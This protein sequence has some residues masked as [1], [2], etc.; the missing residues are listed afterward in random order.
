MAGLVIVGQ[1]AWAVQDR[2][3]VVRTAQHRHLGL[4]V[5]AAMTIDRDL[6]LHSLKADAV[7]V[8]DSALEP[9]AQE[10]FKRAA[11]PADE[12]ASWLLRL[13]CWASRAQPNLRRGCR[14]R[15]RKRRHRCVAKSTRLWSG[16]LR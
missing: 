2:Q 9:L 5:V 12:G 8:A 7:V 13:G 16:S 14:K 1:L 11:D 10:V 15:R 4:D 6:Q 3:R